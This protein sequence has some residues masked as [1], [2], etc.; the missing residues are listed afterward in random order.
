MTVYSDRFKTRPE[1]LA[2]GHP[3]TTARID[4]YRADGENESFPSKGSTVLNRGD[5]VT[6]SI[7][8]G[9]G[10]GDPLDRPR[11]VVESD[12]RNDRVSPEAAR[13]RYGYES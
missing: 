6:V 10:Y 8:G 11:Q 13:E 7:G 12:L 2:G 9:G 3:G 1:G 5:R 4:I